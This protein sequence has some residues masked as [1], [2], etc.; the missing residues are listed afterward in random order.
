MSIAFRIYTTRDAAI[1][2][3]PTMRPQSTRQFRLHI[4]YMIKIVNFLNIAGKRFTFCHVTYKLV[5]RFGKT[6][7]YLFQKI[8]F[9]I[10]LNVVFI[11]CKTYSSII[12]GCNAAITILHTIKI[13]TNYLDNLLI[14]TAS[15]MPATVTT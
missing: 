1:I 5:K 13:I 7:E 2:C 4:L 11:F 15:L 3:S 6:F 10:L 14:G 9:L 12:L 8:L